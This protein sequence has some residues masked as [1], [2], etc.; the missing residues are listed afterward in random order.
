MVQ[1]AAKLTTGGCRVSSD[2]SQLSNGRFSAIAVI[3]LRFTF[4]IC[5]RSVPTLQA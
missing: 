5:R 3:G 2:V 4:Y 1:Q